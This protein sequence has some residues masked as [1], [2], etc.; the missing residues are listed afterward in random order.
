[1][2][3][4]CSYTTPRG[5]F[6]LWHVRSLIHGLLFQNVDVLNQVHSKAQPCMEYQSIRRGP[7]V[8][9]IIQ[10]MWNLMHNVNALGQSCGQALTHTR[11]CISHIVTA[12]L[13]DIPNSMVRTALFSLISFYP[14]VCFMIGTSTSKPYASLTIH[15]YL[16][17]WDLWQWIEP[18]IQRLC[19]LLIVELILSKYIWG[20]PNS[21]N[22]CSVVFNGW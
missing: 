5:W 9:Q 17:A 18:I 1:M 21:G 15:I 14:P 2:G 7:M 11:A 19:E 4:K 10:I 12:S 8:A 22:D 16:P 20:V 13:G 6:T 3:F